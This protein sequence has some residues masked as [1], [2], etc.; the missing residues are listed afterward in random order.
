M[1]PTKDARAFARRRALLLATGMLLA[2]SAIAQETVTYTYDNKGRLTGVSHSGGPAA[3]A[4]ASYNYDNADNR[5]SVAINGATPPS[6]AIGNASAT[7]GSSLTFTVTRS[8]Q[9]FGAYTINFA[10]RSGTATS[11]ADFNGG[12]GTVSFA[13]GQ[14]SAPITIST[15]Q[16]TAVEGNETF[17]VDLSN[18]SGGAPI[19]TATGTGTIVDDDSCSG[20]SFA[21]ASNGAVTEGGTSV[22]TINKAGSTGATCSVNYATASGTATSGSDFNAASGT[23]T[24]SPSQT[25]QTVNVTTVDDTGVESAE[26][27]TLSL[28]SPSGGATL[29]SPSSATATINDNDVPAPTTINLTS[30]GSTNLRTVAN[31]NGYTGATGVTY[32]FVVGSGVTVTGNAGSGIGIDTGTWPSGVTLNLQVNSSGIVRGGGGNGGV[33]GGN[34]TTAAAGGDGGDA[35]RCNAPISITVNS[36]G[37]VQAGGG[38]GGGGGY[39]SYSSPSGGGIIGGG[40]GGGGAPNGFGGTGGAGWNGGAN[41]GNGANGTTS[42]GGAGGTGVGPPGGSGGTYASVGGHAGGATTQGGAPGAGG[43]AVRKNGTGCTLTNSGTVTGT[44]G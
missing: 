29:G 30:G 34:G 3:G 19:T 20:A 38:G 10:T 1:T 43:Y 35:V 11:G 8:G 23:L 25:S 41:G 36:G 4:S 5:S 32:T 15:I 40:G 16:D 33:G 28:S 22:F 42:G 26:T 37:A 24:F 44:V 18:A 21:I 6:F 9:S 7:E 31:N 12:S 27:F 39:A 17:Y 14:T 13:D 2:S